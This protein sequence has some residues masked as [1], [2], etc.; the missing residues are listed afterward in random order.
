MRRD[1]SFQNDNR[2]RRNTSKLKVEKEL[3][4]RDGFFEEQDLDESTLLL[5][6]SKMK[7]VQIPTKKGEFSLL[8]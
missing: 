2:K 1:Y 7:E 4:G 3:K 5:S 6:S 8:W